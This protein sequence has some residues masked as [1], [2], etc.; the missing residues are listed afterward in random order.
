MQLTHFT[1]YGLR[2]LMYLAL[3][4]ENELSNISEL[5]E[6]FNISR[7]H[8]VKII[9]KMSRVGLVE[10]LRGKKGGIRLAKSAESILIGDVIRLLEPLKLIDCS[11]DNCHITHA[12]RL[13]CALEQ[14][15]LAF[16]KE[17]DNY[18]LQD[19]L[20]ENTSLHQLLI[21]SKAL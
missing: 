12:C 9:N 19:M 11:I 7:N 20:T 8:M 16:L 18:S 10:T 17:L 5:T 4:P 21:P 1:D 2:A 14:G 15:M 3:L 13:K 6:K